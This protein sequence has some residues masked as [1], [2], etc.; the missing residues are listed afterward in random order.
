MTR[1]ARDFEAYGVPVLAY[2]WRPPP[3]PTG[4]RIQVRDV[5]DRLE[6]LGLRWYITGSEAASCYGVLRRTYDTDIVLDLEPG[7][8]APVRRA[9]D[10]AQ[11]IVS[12]EID[13][14]DFAMASVIVSATMDK[15]DLILRR[16]S[17]WTESTLQRR[18]RIDHPS[19]GSAWVS[20]LEDL[21]L[22][23]LVWSEGT[24]E[25]QLRDCAILLRVNSG[26]VDDAYLDRWAPALG[27]TGSLDLVRHAD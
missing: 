20:S 27:V 4:Y 1:N 18:Q 2:G 16:T 17:P 6:R 13:Y 8:F 26:R 22:A 19:F 11:H 15:A 7:R 25:L 23:K 14:G 5:L 21:V 10:D 24:S 12:D 9:F 3:S